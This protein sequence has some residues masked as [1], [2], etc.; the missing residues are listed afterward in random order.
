MNLGLFLGNNLY[1]LRNLVLFTKGDAYSSSSTLGT[2][3]SFKLVFFT[4]SNQN[5]S[6]R[7]AI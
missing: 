6:A 7:L 1:M 2:C 4:E 5:L 3:T